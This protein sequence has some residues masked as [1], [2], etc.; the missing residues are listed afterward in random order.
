MRFATTP[1]PC[2]VAWRS[3]RFTP[4]DPYW[5][6]KGTI[7]EV[8]RRIRRFDPWLNVWWSPMRGHLTGC[9]GRWRIV[10]WLPRAVTWSTVFYWETS[11]GDYLPLRPVNQILTKLASAR[12][13]LVEL[14]Q[15]IEE[16]NERRE[17]IRG[18][19]VRQVTREHFIDYAKRMLGLRQTFGPG[20]LRR[21]SF[22][23]GKGLLDPHSNHARWVREMGL[24]R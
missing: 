3:Y 18:S 24:G 5:I 9:P 19:E 20:P 11:E 7:E 14:G 15:R 23:R 10:Q 6:P 8:R 4:P 22:L 21:R 12:H 16:E 13:D 17:R 2:G 1:P